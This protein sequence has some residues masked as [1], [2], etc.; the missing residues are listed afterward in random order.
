MLRIFSIILELGAGLLFCM[1]M[2]GGFMNYMEMGE[3][4]GL[5]IFSSVFATVLL[6]GGLALTSFRNWKRDTGIVLLS[7]SGLMA[8]VILAWIAFD[9]AL[10]RGLILRYIS[11]YFGDYLTG[12][13][14][15]VGFAVLGW[16]LIR[17]DGHSAAPYPHQ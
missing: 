12:G 1:A 3:K 4:A 13:G 11:P 15:I 2:M 16:I 14:T 5:M 9:L 6:C 8:V 17:A 10:T 7:G